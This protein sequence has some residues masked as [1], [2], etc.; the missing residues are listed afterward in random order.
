MLLAGKIAIVTGGASGIGRASALLLAENG[1]TVIV[2]DRE[3]VHARALREEIVGA[4]GSAIDWACDVSDSKA[5][6]RMV[7]HTKTTFSRIDVL[8]H[9][10]GICPRK[11]FLEMTDEDWRAV[12]SVNLDGTFYV[13]RDGLGKP[14]QELFA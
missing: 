14:V 5:V 13:T 7:E 6:A 1:A 10:A 12:L 4:G 9:G 8:V 3:A 11:P 2:A